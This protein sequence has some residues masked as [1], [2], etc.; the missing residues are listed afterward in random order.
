MLHTRIKGA[1]CGC[2][3]LDRG[4][5]WRGRW[6]GSNTHTH[7]R[8]IIVFFFFQSFFS[9]FRSPPSK[10]GENNHPKSQLLLL[11]CC[12]R[13]QQ[14][15]LP[16]KKEKKNSSC[17]LPLYF[18]TTIIITKMVHSCTVHFL[19]NGRVVRLIFLFFFL[20]GKIIFFKKRNK[21]K[22]QFSPNGTHTHT[23]GLPVLSSSL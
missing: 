9:S 14:Q 10:T 21:N 18:W 2:Y 8:L 3:T 7:R 20:R 22:L 12:F 13:V 15:Q 5:K 6:R 19:Y 16:R 11:C 23:P 1:E 17:S 4:R